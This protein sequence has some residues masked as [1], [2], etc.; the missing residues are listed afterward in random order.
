LLYH[1]GTALIALAD[2]PRV[3][4][5]FLCAFYENRETQPGALVEGAK[6]LQTADPLTIQLVT[7]EP[8]ECGVWKVVGMAEATATAKGCDAVKVNSDHSVTGSLAVTPDDV[9]DVS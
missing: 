2:E 1:L 5:S 4:N 9:Q 6:E 7:K 8:F 3:M